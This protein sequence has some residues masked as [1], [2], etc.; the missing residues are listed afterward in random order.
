MVSENV[1]LFFFL[2]FIFNYF[3]VIV[4]PVFFPYLVCAD[5][6]EKSH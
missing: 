2:S 3:F 6:I 4:H 5:L 1:S